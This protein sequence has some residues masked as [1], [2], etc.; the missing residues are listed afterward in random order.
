MSVEQ[1]LYAFSISVPFQ[2]ISNVDGHSWAL[3]AAD[4]ERPSKIFTPLNKEQIPITDSPVVVQQHNVPPQKFILLSAKVETAVTPLP[5]PQT[6]L[7]LKS[8]T[9][10]CLQFCQ[11]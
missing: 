7:T 5:A 3:C 6:V 2:M 11:Y 1:L 10:H 9:E 8:G 4:E